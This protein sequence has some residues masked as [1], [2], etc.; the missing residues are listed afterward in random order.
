MDV[1]HVGLVHHDPCKYKIKSFCAV[2][3]IEMNVSM[4]H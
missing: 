2:S 1:A 4:K 3:S